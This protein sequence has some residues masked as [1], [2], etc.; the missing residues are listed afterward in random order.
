M[1]YPNIGINTVARRA[2]GKTHRLG[3]AEKEQNK[4]PETKPF[5]P[6]DSQGQPGTGKMPHLQ[7]VAT[8]RVVRS[9]SRINSG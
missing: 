9:R 1:A 6:K 4:A 7:W 2:Q 8:Y 3:N 5:P